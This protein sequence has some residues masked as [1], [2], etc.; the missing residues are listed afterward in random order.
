[1]IQKYDEVGR[2]YKRRKED[3]NWVGISIFIVLGL[4][5]VGALMG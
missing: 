3:S 4:C 2:V 1:M 5:V